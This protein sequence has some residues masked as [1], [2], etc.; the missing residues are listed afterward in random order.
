MTLAAPISSIPDFAPRPMALQ[1]SQVKFAYAGHRPVLDGVNLQV[2]VGERVGLIGPNGAGKTTLFLSI[3]GV[4]AAS[5][6]RIDL[7]DR[8]V[9]LK[10]FRPEVGLVF[11]NAADQLFSLSVQEDV[12]FGPINMGMDEEAVRVQVA[13]ALAMTGTSHLAERAPHHLS[14]GERRMVAIAS[15]LAMQPQ[16]MI[17]D[18][19]SANLDLRARRRLI[20]FLQDSPQTLVI[21][22]HDLELVLDVCDRV[23]LLDEGKILA[24]GAPHEIMANA[25]LME[26]HGLEVPS[27]LH[28]SSQA[29]RV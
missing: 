10:E 18:E 14:G 20:Q 5:S 29:Y 19:P 1:L 13:D 11:Q 12:A 23:I 21:S 4:L 8:P 15:V 25:A 6:G 28:A 2:H 27:A 26:A 7:F 22:S 24:D 3:C 17:Y 16:L 9:K